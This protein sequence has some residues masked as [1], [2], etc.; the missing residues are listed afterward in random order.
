MIGSTLFVAVWLFYLACRYVGGT[1]PV[2]LASYR[3]FE[4]R[5]GLALA[6]IYAKRSDLFRSKKAFA[7]RSG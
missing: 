6:S 3:I 2:S 1:V 4:K 7:A 5:M